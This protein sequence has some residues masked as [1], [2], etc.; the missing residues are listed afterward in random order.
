MNWA[1]GKRVGSRRPTGAHQVDDCPKTSTLGGTRLGISASFRCDERVTS[2]C[3]KCGPLP[4]VDTPASRTAETPCLKGALAC[5]RGDT[6]RPTHSSISSPWLA[7][8]ELRAPVHSYP[9]SLTMLRSVLSLWIGILV[10]TCS[11]MALP[12]GATT[13]TF[14]QGTYQSY[15]STGSAAVGYGGGRPAGGQPTGRPGY[16]LSG[17]ELSGGM[18]I[19]NAQ[20][21]GGRPG[22][23]GRSGS[24]RV[25]PN[26]CQAT[27]SVRL[28][29]TSCWRRATGKAMG[30]VVLVAGLARLRGMDES[31]GPVARQS[32]CPSRGEA[33]D[34]AAVS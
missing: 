16:E 8:S 20:V 1:D 27:C 14:A 17:D 28:I 5:C 19:H 4:Y 32:A 31:G 2:A 23:D 10:M 26:C 24:G 34:G 3:F 11:T 30:E 6:A 18:P 13:S 7:S 29:T 21:Q 12:Q 33:G 22:S 9:P 25:S 15:G